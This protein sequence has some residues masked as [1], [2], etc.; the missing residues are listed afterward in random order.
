MVSMN[1]SSSNLGVAVILVRKRPPALLVGEGLTEGFSAGSDRITGFLVVAT[2]FLTSASLLSGDV[3]TD[4]LSS[5]S[6]SSSAAYQF[7]L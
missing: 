5:S 4:S 6:S 2:V 1:H 3:E 7:S